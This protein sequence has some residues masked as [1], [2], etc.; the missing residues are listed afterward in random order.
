[1][2]KGREMNAEYE[3][4]LHSLLEQRHEVFG[5]SRAGGRLC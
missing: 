1:M 3:P 2:A 4:L 5:L